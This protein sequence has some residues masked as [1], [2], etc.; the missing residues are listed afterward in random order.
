MKQIN[1]LTEKDPTLSQMRWAI[2][3]IWAVTASLIF[4]MFVK[5]SPLLKPPIE[6]TNGYM[7]HSDYIWGQIR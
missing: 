4:S 5:T 6:D 3:I 2:L 7:L 1:Y